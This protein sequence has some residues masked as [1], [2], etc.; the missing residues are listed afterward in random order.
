MSLQPEKIPLLFTT[1]WGDTGFGTVGK[2]LMQRLAFTKLFDLYYLG[3]HYR[4]D[5]SGKEVAEALGFKLINTAF[6][7]MGDLYGAQ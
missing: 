1:D 4:G 7:I 6:W 3:W 2:E 5:Q